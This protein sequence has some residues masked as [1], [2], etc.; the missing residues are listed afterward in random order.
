MLPILAAVALL[1][2]SVP[3][4]TRPPVVWAVRRTWGHRALV[5]RMV[6]ADADSDEDTDD[7]QDDDPE[8]TTVL[9]PLLSLSSGPGIDEVIR[10]EDAE[11]LGDPRL[12]QFDVGPF[13]SS[14]G[15]RDGRWDDP[16]AEPAF[17]EC[18]DWH[19]SSTYT[20][21]DLAAAAEEEARLS[22]PAE[23]EVEEELLF[24]ADDY[25]FVKYDKGEIT[26]EPF[27]PSHRMPTSWQEYQA[28]QKR[29]LAIAGE[30]TGGCTPAERSK[31]AT[32]AADLELFYPSFKAILAEG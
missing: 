17:L 20:A 31:A 15:I 21:D 19:V 6:D 8:A 25:E 14:L 22:L 23:V 1:A 7:D 12:R 26:P 32:M 2:P 27:Q 30:T 4:V 9:E 16:A 11:H 18:E 10:A 5:P 28:L 29:V 13:A 24:A 3:C